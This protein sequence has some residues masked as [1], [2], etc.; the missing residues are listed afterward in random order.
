[1][2]FRR[3]IN[4]LR[5]MAVLAVILFHFRIP[6]FTGGYLGVDIFF[7]I[8][9]YL[10]SRIILEGFDNS[11]F[12]L[13]GFYIRRVKRI[14][15]ALVVLILFVLAVGLFLLFPGE[16]KL[17]SQYAASSMAFVSN[18]HYW[19]K[20][21]YFDLASQYNILLH[22][23]SL[24]VEWQFYLIYPLL[25]MCI[26]R[27][28]LTRKGLF[29]ALIISS[30]VLT[31]AATLMIFNNGEIFAFFSFP[32]RSWEMVMGCVVFL[33]EK[34]FAEKVPERIRNTLCI[35]GYITLIFCITFFTERITW[36]SA[37]TAIPV[38][39]TFLILVC[40][41]DFSLQGNKVVQWTGKISYSLYLWHWPLF[42]F[43]AYLGLSRPS[44]LAGTS[45]LTVLFAWLSYKYVESNKK[46]IITKRALAG[47]IATFAFALFM[48]FVPLNRFFID[49]KIIDLAN[50]QENHKDEIKAQMSTGDCFIDTEDNILENFNAAGCLRFSDSL[51][52][53]LLI[54]DS[55]AAMLSPSLKNELAG[56]NKNLLQ[57]TSGAAHF[58]LNPDEEHNSAKFVK[59]I[60]H[61]FIPQNAGRIETIFFSLYFWGLREDTDEGARDRLEELEKYLQGYNIKLKIIGYTPHYQISYTTIAAR[62]MM[63]HKSMDKNYEDKDV[64]K[65]NNFL[66][67]CFPDSV[68][69]DIYDIKGIK[70][71]EDYTPWMYDNSHL[72]VFG[73]DQVVDYLAKKGVLD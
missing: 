22:T 3:D 32:T 53:V 58:V 35:T 21:G 16:L 68:Y 17:L 38:A 1:M 6:Y 28:Y 59:Y 39:A 49:K 51:N 11:G 57:A 64:Y 46:I 27:L 69:I 33:F 12:S 52:N 14:V 60:L 71:I 73:A 61:E 42:V 37:Y 55:H 25:L 63:V 44:I 62:E 31:Y 9:G 43:A 10:M 7:V 65:Q 29:K 5:A 34:D 4:A 50:Y 54:G 45:A 30:V 41:C 2:K 8:S 23:W 20:S 66:K 18:M 56:R 24:S 47:G 48:S 15:P 19:L 72:T 70:K 40:Q 26:R 36:P 67:S 13:K